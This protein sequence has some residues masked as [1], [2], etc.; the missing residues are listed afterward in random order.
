MGMGR[1]TRARS[2]SDDLSLMASLLAPVTGVCI[3]QHDQE[4]GRLQVGA[5]V[6]GLSYV[7]L[8]VVGTTHWSITIDGVSLATNSSDAIAIPGC[9]GVG[10][11]AIVDSGTSLMALPRSV[12]NTVLSMIGTIEKDC[13]NVDQLPNV[14]FSAGEHHFDLPPQLY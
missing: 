9:E 10:C 8:P 1:E 13:S 2:Y 12:L 14:R 5:E 11:Q 7:S 6:P 4:A 3:G